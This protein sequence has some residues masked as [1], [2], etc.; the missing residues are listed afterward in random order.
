MTMM[1]QFAL[2]T[3]M[4]TVF[5]LQNL[6][7]TTFQRVTLEDMLQPDSVNLC[8]FYTLFSGHYM[9]KCFSMIMTTNILESLVQYP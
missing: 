5:I 3:S 7:R 2:M 6:F 1:I 4:M 8:N 9:A